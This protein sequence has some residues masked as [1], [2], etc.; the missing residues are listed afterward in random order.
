MERQDELD[1]L[2]CVA[3]QDKDDAADVAAESSEKT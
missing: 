1:L 3:H 2:H